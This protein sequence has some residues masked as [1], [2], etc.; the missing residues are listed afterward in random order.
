MLESSQRYIYGPTAVPRS[1]GSQRGPRLL[2]QSLLVLCAKACFDVFVFVRQYLAVWLDLG[3]SVH[4]ILQAHSAL[5][6]YPPL[7]A[8]LVQSARKWQARA[9]T[10]ASELSAQQRGAV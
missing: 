4:S 3:S 2:Q 5:S 9:K 8:L 6:L 1:C 10:A 7:T